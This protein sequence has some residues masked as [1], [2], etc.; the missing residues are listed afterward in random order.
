MNRNY[1]VSLLFLVPLALVGCTANTPAAPQ[2]AKPSAAPV[3]PNPPTSDAA[4]QEDERL[5]REI[6]AKRKKSKSADLDKTD[7]Y[8]KYV[9]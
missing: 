7:A 5:E 6:A 3:T 1:I 8:R 2:P 4:K 9:P